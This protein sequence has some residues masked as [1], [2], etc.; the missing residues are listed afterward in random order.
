MGTQL[1]RLGLY[2]VCVGEV[3]PRIYAHFGI[4]V[5]S[6][7]PSA[8]KRETQDIECVFGFTPLVWDNMVNDTN[9]P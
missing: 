8:T 9:K 2:C 1:V 4:F 6:Q 3:C 5:R 7:V